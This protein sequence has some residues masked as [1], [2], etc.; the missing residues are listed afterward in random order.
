MRSQFTLLVGLV[1]HV[2]ACAFPVDETETYSPEP[3]STVESAET[4]PPLDCVTPYTRVDPRDGVEK[5]IDCEFVCADCRTQEDCPNALPT[6]ID[7]C[8]FQLVHPEG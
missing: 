5:T 4:G 1:L 6:A 8:L 7:I 2:S 3:V